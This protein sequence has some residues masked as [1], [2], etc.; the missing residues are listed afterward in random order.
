MLPAVHRVQGTAMT[1]TEKADPAVAPTGGWVY[2]PLQPPE[3]AL[4]ESMDISP[5]ADILRRRATEDIDDVL[6]RLQSKV[7]QLTEA[8]KAKDAQIGQLQERIANMEFMAESAVTENELIIAAE[9]SRCATEQLEN[10]G[11]AIRSVADDTSAVTEELAQGVPLV[12]DGK[13]AEDVMKK[14][15]SSRSEGD[16]KRESVAEEDLSEIEKLRQRVAELTSELE[17]LKA[18]KGGPLPVLANSGRK[19]EHATKARPSPRTRTSTK[20]QSSASEGTT[21]NLDQDVLSTSPEMVEEKPAEDPAVEFKKKI[22]GMGGINPLMGL[23][24]GMMAG[25]LK[26][27]RLS[28]TQSQETGLELGDVDEKEL[29][30][31]IFKTIGESSPTNPADLKELLKD[32]QLLCRL[33]NAVRPDSSLKINTGKFA[34]ARLENINNYLKAAEATGVAKQ[35]NFS[36]T[37]LQNGDNYTVVLQNIADLRK[38][39]TQKK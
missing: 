39:I 29:K 28:R 5:S 32:G 38:I 31:W 20:S 33:M 25:Q 26:P 15:A 12:A 23:N 37:D 14:I 30:D 1:M 36:A 11:S 13:S 16:Q 6:T 27:G 21:K 19:L 24:P 2:S 10:I 17:S 35:Y 4:S 3:A 18:A 9:T 34:F 8:V 22:A 7:V